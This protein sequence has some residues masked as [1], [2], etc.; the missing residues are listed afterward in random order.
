MEEMERAAS[1]PLEGNP[2][3]SRRA[4]EAWAR[5]WQRP[6]DVAVPQDQ[7]LEEQT[8]GSLRQGRMGSPGGRRMG[9]GMANGSEEFVTPQDGLFL[10][11]SWSRQRRSEGPAPTEV[12]T[13]GPVPGLNRREMEEDM[14]FQREVE[15]GMMEHLVEENEKLKV[16]L[17]NL[18]EQ[19]DRERFQAPEMRTED[20][21]Y[22]RLQGW[23]EAE[24]YQRLQGWT[25]AE[26]ET[27]YQR[28]AEGES[29]KRWPE[30]VPRVS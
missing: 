15:R 30:D 5:A 6:Q 19:K 4:S 16:E 9:L 25:E 27:G 29:Y 7:D 24:R 10:P 23:T 8:A 21:R 18:Q 12:R 20:E 11:A 26:R 22:Q 17:R 13:E 28:N 1:L 3:W 2:F 14:E